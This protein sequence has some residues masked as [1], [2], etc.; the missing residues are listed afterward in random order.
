ML[1]SIICRFRLFA[2]RAF[3]VEPHFIFRGLF[4]VNL[5]TFC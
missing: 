2:A 5:C 4:S 3:P 1:L